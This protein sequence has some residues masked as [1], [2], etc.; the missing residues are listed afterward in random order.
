[1]NETE[2]NANDM[3]NNLHKLGCNMSIKSALSAFW[4][5]YYYGYGEQIPKKMELK[6][7][8]KLLLDVE[9]RWTG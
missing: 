4:Y 8:G 7:D 5:W 2:E 1:M 3:L 9:E 6:Q